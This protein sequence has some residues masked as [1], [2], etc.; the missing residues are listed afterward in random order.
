MN[1]KNKLSLVML[2]VVSLSACGDEDINAVKNFKPN[3]GNSIADVLD[4]WTLCSSTS[5][6]KKPGVNNT[7]IVEYTCKVSH[8]NDYVDDVRGMLTENIKLYYGRT[9]TNED[10]ANIEKITDLKNIDINILFE[11]GRHKQA[12][13]YR[14]MITYHWN[15][16]LSGSAD[17]MVSGVMMAA[18]TNRGS[19]FDIMDGN[20]QGMANV[21]IASESRM[22]IFSSIRDKASKNKNAD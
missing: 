6:S 9:P 12:I 2:M 18:K 4:S 22:K 15:D 16:G 3:G 5:W 20:P 19:F 21:Y 8:V 10:K 1:K 17:N 13:P 14:S 7:V 11:L